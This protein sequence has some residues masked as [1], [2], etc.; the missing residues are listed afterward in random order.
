MTCVMK[1]CKKNH[2]HV[3]ISDKNVG[4]LRRDKTK[5]RNLDDLVRRGEVRLDP[6]TRK[7]LKTLQSEMDKI[8]PTLIALSQD[9]A[10]SM[11]VKDQAQTALKTFSDL[12]VAPEQ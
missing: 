5:W 10:E 2:R 7:S 11:E 6:E 8:T 9:A 3:I 4:P 12:P 1:T